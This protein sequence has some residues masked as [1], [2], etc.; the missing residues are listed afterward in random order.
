[1][2]HQLRSP[3]DM[4]YDYALDPAEE[5]ELRQ[6]LERA[7]VEYHTAES[8]KQEDARQRYS[9]TLRRFTDYVMRRQS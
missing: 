2:Q 5:R 4:E 7:C 9:E 1:M 8:Q 6:A 3:A